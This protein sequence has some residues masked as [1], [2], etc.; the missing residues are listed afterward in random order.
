ME[1]LRKIL[2]DSLNIE[3]IMAVLSSPR[4]KDQAQKVKVR[5]VLKQEHTFFLSM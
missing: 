1:E 3:F 4:T 5:P 2:E